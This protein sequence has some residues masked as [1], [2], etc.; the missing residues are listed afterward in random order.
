MVSLSN[1]TLRA[2][3]FG[4]TGHLGPIAAHHGLLFL[5]APA[6]DLL[7]GS[8]GFFTGREVLR[9]N[10]L[11]G[12]PFEGVATGYRTRMVFL[13]AFLDIVSVAGVVAAVGATEDVNPE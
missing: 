12:T 7:F 11:K 10:Q 5:A 9:K 3:G 6:F 13:N 8:Q 1:R 4:E 2:S